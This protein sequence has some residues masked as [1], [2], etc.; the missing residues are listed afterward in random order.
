MTFKCHFP[1]VTPVTSISLASIGGRM[2]DI[3]LTS[4]SCETF[5][6]SCP[7]LHLLHLNVISLE[8]LVQMLCLQY[9][10][11]LPQN[12]IC[13]FPWISKHFICFFQIVFIFV[14]LRIFLLFLWL[15]DGSYNWV[16]ILKG[17]LLILFS[18]KID[19]TLV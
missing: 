17:K 3:S 15:F 4:F 6:V 5:V 19:E 12:L 8:V 2:R 1:V 9:I 7:V 10:L 11:P 16:E 13:F 18:L 14:F